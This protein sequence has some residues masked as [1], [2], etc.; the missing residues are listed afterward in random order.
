MPFTAKTEN[1]KK[2]IKGIK[3]SDII[4]CTGMAGTGKSYVAIGYAL[5]LLNR[6]RIDKIY[7]SRP[8][9]ST[10]GRDFPFLKGTLE[11]KLHPYYY[12]LYCIFYDLVGKKDTH[13]MIE[14][15]TIEIVPIELMRGLTFS[16]C[17]VII[18]E[19]QNIDPQQAV[20]SITRMGENCKMIYTGDTKQTDLN[21]YGSSSYNGLEL[22]LDGLKNRPDLAFH[23]KML[24]EDVL[25][26]PKIADILKAL[27]WQGNV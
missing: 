12:P 6:G 21:Y 3:E 20:M 5:E 19:A 18:D 25:R 17:V 7:L 26:N 27:D 2:Y 4:I 16:D 13:K 15:G 23:I 24:P 8:M 10:G 9:E 22:L 1:Q 14:N 11:E